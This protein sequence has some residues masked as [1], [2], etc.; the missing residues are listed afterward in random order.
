M[1]NPNMV[2]QQLPIFPFKGMIES[3]QHG[4]FVSQKIDIL[5]VLTGCETANRYNV[6]EMDQEG[7]KIG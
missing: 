2:M 7:N 5:E 6:F 1:Q 3:F 4:I